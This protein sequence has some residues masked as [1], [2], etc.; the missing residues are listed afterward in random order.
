MDRKVFNKE[1]ELMSW[2]EWKARSL[3]RLFKELGV[4]KQPGRITAETVRHG[5]EAR[6]KNEKFYAP[7]ERKPSGPNAG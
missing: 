4:L 1:P 2:Y 7:E 3:N 5:E 6:R